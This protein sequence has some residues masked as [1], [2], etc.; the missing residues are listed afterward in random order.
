MKVAFTF[1]DQDL[2]SNYIDGMNI[3]KYINSTTVNAMTYFAP[4]NVDGSTMYQLN[5]HSSICKEE[6][7]RNKTFI[8]NFFFFDSASARC[9]KEEELT[10]ISDTQI[11]YYKIGKNRQKELLGYNLDTILLSHMPIPQF[12]KLLKKK[13]TKNFWGSQ[14]EQVTTCD[15]QYD[16]FEEI[17]TTSAVKYVIA[18]Y[19]G[20]NDFGGI[21]GKNVNGEDIL[22]QYAGS[23]GPR[24]HKEMRS[25]LV[26]NMKQN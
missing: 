13:S 17:L 14:Y 16:D 8:S 25:V 22:L 9:S 20:Q 7:Y 4:L 3:L 21:Y 26:L 24:G 10:A 5:L 1:G 23:A 15:R 6:E 2:H 18:G 19:D 12:K 11:Q